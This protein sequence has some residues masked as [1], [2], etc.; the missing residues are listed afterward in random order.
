MTGTRAMNSCGQGVTHGAERR[1][2]PTV[3]ANF[4]AQ[5]TL[6]GKAEG[7]SD[8]ATVIDISERGWLS[9]AIVR[10]VWEPWLS[11]K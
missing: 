1:R 4:N 11:Y 7:L 10:S 3:R 5:I 6:L 2:E 8:T 9:H